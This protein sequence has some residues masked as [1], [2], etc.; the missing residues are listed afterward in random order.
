MIE[1]INPLLK[2]ILKEQCDRV[3]ELGVIKLL[4]IFIKIVK[5]NAR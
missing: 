5:L 4:M 1:T 2:L 3:N